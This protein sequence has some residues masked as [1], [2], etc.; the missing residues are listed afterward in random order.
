M[1]ELA[2]HAAAKVKES[3]ADILLMDQDDIKLLVIQ[4]GQ[5]LAARF[6]IGD[7]Q[8]VR[9]KLCRLYAMDE[10]C[11]YHENFIIVNVA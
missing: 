2:G 7:E 6:D 10:V 5:Q 11:F 4:I 3:R 1:Q 9:Y 8:I